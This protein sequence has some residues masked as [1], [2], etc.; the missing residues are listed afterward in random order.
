MPESLDNTGFLGHDGITTW[1]GL[2]QAAA[3]IAQMQKPDDIV[4]F[5]MADSTFRVV[6]EHVGR[7]QSMRSYLGAAFGLPVHI[8]NDLDHMALEGVQ[9]NGER[10][11][12][13]PEAV[14]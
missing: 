14:P 6:S 5:Y 2:L 1:D 8:D 9:R 11:Q 7:G 10:R 4:A 13:H 12:L 3:Q